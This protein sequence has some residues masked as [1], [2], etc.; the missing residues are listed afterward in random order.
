MNYWG[1]ELMVNAYNCDTNTITSKSNINEFIVKLCEMT[2]ME[3]VGDT[4]YYE[5][6]KTEENDKNDITGLTAFQ[7]I[8][9]SN[10]T[11]HF[12]NKSGSMYLNF[13]SCKCYDFEKVLKLLMEY[14][15]F[16]TYSYKNLYRNSITGFHY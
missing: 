15:K 4:I 8:K 16:T 14:F 3:K 10:I 11:I 12:C 6:E 1:Q 5:V 2:E 9:T 13:F 7:F